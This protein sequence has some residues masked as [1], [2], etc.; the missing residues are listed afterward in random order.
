MTSLCAGQ[1]D[2]PIACVA[3]DVQCCT[4]NFLCWDGLHTRKSPDVGEIIYLCAYFQAHS[5]LDA[6]GFLPP[7]FFPL[8]FLGIISIGVHMHTNMY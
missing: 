6:I 1:V 7:A 4:C 5:S 3:S 2:P 8:F